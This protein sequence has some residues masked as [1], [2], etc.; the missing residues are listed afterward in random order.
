MTNLEN[1]NDELLGK[2]TNFGR[3]VEV[4][5]LDFL[6]SL[7]QGVGLERRLSNKQNVHHASDGPDVSLEAV[8]RFQ[9]DLGRDVVGRAAERSLLFADE[10]NFRGKTKVADLDLKFQ[11]GNLKFHPSSLN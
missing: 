7:R 11:I 2:R 6:V 1:V 3:N 10:F 4:G 5:F 9:Q 8:A